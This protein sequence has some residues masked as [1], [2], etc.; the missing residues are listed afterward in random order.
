MHPFRGGSLGT[1]ADLF[2]G[3]MWCNVSAAAIEHVREQHERLARVVRYLGRCQ[4]PDEALLPTLLLNAAGPLRVCNDRKRFIRWVP[5]APH[6]EVLEESDAADIE[7]GSD[8]F[9]RK[10][11]L[12]RSKDLLDRLDAAARVYGRP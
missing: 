11:D 8:F 1:G 12:V 9:A 5:G 2:I 6:P 3:D 10:V 4:I 7:T